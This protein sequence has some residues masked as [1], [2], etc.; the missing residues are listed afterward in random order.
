[1]E[2]RGM[3][4]GTEVTRKLLDLI[5]S[6]DKKLGIIHIAGTNGKG[7]VAEYL[8]RILVAAGY[9]TGTFSS[10]D[11]FSENDGVR[12]NCRPIKAA[13]YERALKKAGEAARGTRATAFEIQTAAVL[14]LFAAEKCAYAVVECGLGGL[15]D[16]TNAIAEKELALISSI[17]LE[18]T[19]VLGNDIISICRH[20]AGIIKDITRAI[21]SPLQPVEARD[22][23]AALGAS[24]A[25]RPKDVTAVPGGQTFTLCGEKYSIRLF[26][27]AQPYNASL[28]ASAALRLGVSAQKIREG[29][30]AAEL[31][32]RTEV[33]AEGGNEY[34]LDGCH[35]P[36]AFAEFARFLK[37]RY[38]N[39]RLEIVVGFLKDKDVSGCMEKLSGLNAVITAVTPACERGR[40]KYSTAGMCREVFGEVYTAES[41][42]E[43]L[44]GKRGTIV[45]CGSFTLLKEARQWIEKKL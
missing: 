27:P 33:I 31:P 42:T 9:K 19:D 43:A 37:E 35:N 8:S 28:A 23:F 38:A 44:R 41:V 25:P 29:L 11:V 1:M 3:R 7:S 34:V 39:V 18:H 15:A 14:E 21:V 30:A 24:F 26:G 40:D 16:A 6:P 36:P 5:G 17:G 10:P 13:D 32:G 22:Y 45:V 2:I 12:I 20:K 4:F